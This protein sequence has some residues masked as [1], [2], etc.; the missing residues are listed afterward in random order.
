MAAAPEDAGC[1]VWRAEWNAQE[2]SRVKVWKP[3]PQGRWMPG[4]TENGDFT[5]PP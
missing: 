2:T 1:Q 4:C 5:S 3:G